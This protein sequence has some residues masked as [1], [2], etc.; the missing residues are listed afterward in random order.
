M[1]MKAEKTDHAIA[2]EEEELDDDIWAR[3]G[4]GAL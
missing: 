3:E 1:R 4:H 2:D